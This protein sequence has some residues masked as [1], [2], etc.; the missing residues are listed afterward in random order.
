MKPTLIPALCLAAFSIASC[1]RMGV[2]AADASTDAGGNAN[3][4]AAFS[5]NAASPR[6]TVTLATGTSVAVRLM[7]ALDTQRNRAGDRFDA[8]LAEPLVFGD[9]V[10]VPK[11][12]HFSG[13]IIEAKDS[14]RFRGRAAMALTLDSFDLNGRNYPI[15]STSSVRASR[16]HKKRNWLWMGGGSGGGAAIGA[17]AG[18][19]MGALIGAG[20]GAAA[21]TVG[22]AFTGKQHVLLPIE[23]RVTFRLESPVSIGG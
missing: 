4:G 19:G 3:A 23:T 2:P 16:G 15:Q 14:G 12:T 1:G 20:A 17:I 7:E 13:H 21:G 9:R 6:P 18:G 11:G 10:I 5:P 8:E 22:A